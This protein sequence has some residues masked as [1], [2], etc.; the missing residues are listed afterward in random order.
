ML[1]QIFL[2]SGNAESGKDTT[3]NLMMNMLYGKSVKTSFAFYLKIIAQT[4]FGWNGEK[5]EDGRQLLQWLGTDIIHEILGREFHVKRICEDIKIIQNTYDYVFIPDTRFKHEIFYTKAMFPYN[6]TTIRVHR[7]N[8]QNKLTE[9]QR[10][11]ISEVDL[12]N[13][14]HDYHIDN[15]GDGLNDLKQCIYKSRLK[16]MIDDFNMLMRG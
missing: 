15:V 3:A 12:K 9:E 10:N 2:I 16:W 11:H 7:P 5:D 6:V 1:K 8:H 14:L 4:Y 13:F